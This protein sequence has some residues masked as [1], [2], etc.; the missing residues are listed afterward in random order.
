MATSLQ[1]LHRSPSKAFTLV[2][3]LVVIA[4]IGVLVSL[5]LPAVQAAREAARRMSCGN[6]LKQIGLGLLNYENTYNE[7]PAGSFGPDSS[8]CVSEISTLYIG[9]PAAENGWQRSL[10]SAFVPLLAYV[11]QQQLL[12]L[13]ALDEG[14]SARGI[15]RAGAFGG[16]SAWRVPPYG[17][18]RELAIGTRP[19]VYVCAS[20]TAEEVVTPD[21]NG[22]D[23]FTNW[24]A[25][26]S[27][28]SYAFSMGHRGPLAWGTNT[29][30]TKF[31][32]TGMFVYHYKTELRQITDGA[33]NTIAA[34]ETVDGH[35]VESSNMWTYAE[36]FCNSLRSTEAAINTP[37]G[38]D[39]SFLS[40]KRGG[41][42]I[43]G[44]FASRH[45]GGAQFVYGDGRV[46]F[47]QEEID[48][49]TYQ[50]L[51]TID[52]EPDVLDQIDS[53]QY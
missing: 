48:L 7:F 16:D 33:S 47:I 17:E 34:G 40:N 41:A 37:P 26:P 27:T 21:D 46:E 43:N 13:F 44:A 50:Q 35:T 30:M 31:F 10:Y 22:F 51:S 4:I 2:E 1:K 32:N 29:C 53:D 15:W 36:R 25:T 45:P 49:D 18:Q 20:D 52:G 19:G 14:G 11:E 12:N 24:A 23:P 6:N 28:G 5:L 8:S 42:I 3:L 39:G 9:Q 38:F